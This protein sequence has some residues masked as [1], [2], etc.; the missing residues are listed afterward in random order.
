MDVHRKKM[1]ESIRPHLTGVYRIRACRS[2]LD[3]ARRL[4]PRIR[5]FMAVRDHALKL[6]FWP[7]GNGGQTVDMNWDWIQACDNLGIGEL[8]LDDTISGHDNLRIIFFKPDIDAPNCGEM[9]LIW[10]L[11][12]I[13]K[14]RQNFTPNDIRT[15]KARRA[16][17]LSFHYRRTR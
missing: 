10:I 13:Q 1:K 8:R 16:L 15:F 11:H 17:V 7:G 12:V 9:P 5:D 2:A 6:R 3:G 4:F 14:K